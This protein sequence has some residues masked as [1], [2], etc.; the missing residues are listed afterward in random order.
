MSTSY[1][2]YIKMRDAWY[3]NIL[4]GEEKASLTIEFERYRNSE[5]IKT[6]TALSK[7][8]RW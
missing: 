5:C 4:P 1:E 6:G 7:T 8:L 3:Q 2:S